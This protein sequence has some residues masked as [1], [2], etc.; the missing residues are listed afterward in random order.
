MAPRKQR[1][2]GAHDRE[3]KRWA[4]QVAQGLVS[5]AR[6]GR[7]I[8]PGALWDLDHAPDGQSYL[9]PSH[10]RCNRRT[11]A[12]RA[13]RRVTAEPVSSPGTLS[14]REWSELPERE[15]EWRAGDL[16]PRRRHSRE[17]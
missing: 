1:Y 17:W 7:L 8:E 4:P 2:R 11:A 6:C 9:G 12:H 13:A 10:Q 15:R 5:C 3:R 16:N 14:A